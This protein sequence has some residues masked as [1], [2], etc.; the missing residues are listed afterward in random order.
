MANLLKKA[1]ANLI[2]PDAGPAR[3]GPCQPPARPD[4]PSHYERRRE[5]EERPAQDAGR[6]AGRQR[7][8]RA[9]DHVSPGGPA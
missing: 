7:L 6:A 5:E 3:P 8:L 4:R 9:Q 2:R 1:E